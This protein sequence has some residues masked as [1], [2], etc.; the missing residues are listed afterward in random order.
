MGAFFLYKQDSRIQ[1]KAVGDVFE[2]KGFREPRTFVCGEYN[3]LLWQKQLVE[4]AS[5][6][7]REGA[8]LC[9]VGT[10]VYRGLSYAPS[11]NAIL[12][13]FLRGE[14]KLERLR[15]NF[16]LIFLSNGRVSFLNDALNV[17]HLFTDKARSFITSSFL[18]AMNALPD[19]LTLNRVTCLEKLLT[20]YTVGSETLFNEVVHIARSTR[21]SCGWEF[22]KMSP[23]TVPDAEGRSRKRNIQ[24]RVEKIR[25]YFRDITPLKNEFSPE[26]GLSDGYDSRLLYA[27]ALD[28]WRQAIGVHTHS[29]E[30][31]GAH[32]A[33]REIVKDIASAFGSELTVIKTKRMLNYSETEIEDILLDGLYFFDGRCAYNTGAF[34]P[35]YTRKYKIATAGKHR[36]TLNGLGG[37]IYRNYYL[38]SKPV[39]SVKQWMKA[40]VYTSAVDDV[41]GKGLFKAIHEDL[42]RKVSAEMGTRWK[43]CAANF[44]MRR[45]YS[46]IV[47]PDCNALNCN[48]HNQMLFYVTPFIEWDVMHD[49]YK[50]RKALGKCGELQAGIM[51]V[52]NERVASFPSHYGF[53]LNQT[54]PLRY[55]AYVF[56]KGWLPDFIW[57]ART[58]RALKTLNR[59]LEYF[60]R[61]AEKCKYL[62]A[63]DAYLRTLFPEVNFDLLRKDYAM[64]PNSAYVAVLLYTFRDRIDVASEIE[65]RN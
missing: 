7:E 35:V 21:Q 39:I 28:V 10:V 41:I 17:Q 15:G 4:C 30:G 33:E 29:T 3:L 25:E 8:T 46:E 47:L 61:T 48:A 26:I 40:H 22:I 19:K 63:A 65:R 31:A 20:G 55:R 13:D 51:R 34:S 42:V 59:D 36:L 5:W 2:K 62:Q 24:R 58:R 54:P 44:T 43:N 32:D 16:C 18:A 52:L 49:A 45:F 11:L 27:G 9:A 60:G 57:N 64:M 1:T 50:A 56:V 53:P 38:V 23:L 12:V 14:L 37:E 6:T